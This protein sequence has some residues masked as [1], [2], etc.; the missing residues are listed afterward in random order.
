VPPRAPAS[1]EGE[2]ANPSVTDLP[3]KAIVRVRIPFNRPKKEGEGDE[4]ADESK[5]VEEVKDEEEEE[6]KAEE[7]P[8]EENTEDLEEVDV[9]DRAHCISTIGD[10]YK[11]WAIHQ[12]ATRWVR[13]DIAKELKK[14]L[15]E[16]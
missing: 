14:C 11:I 13:K 7:S 8:E 2:E 1:G 6:K 4:D 10:N 9:E 15:P 16:L 12:A 5:K 3:L